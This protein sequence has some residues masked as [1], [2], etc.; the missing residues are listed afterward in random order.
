MLWGQ[1]NRSYVIWWAY[2][3]ATCTLYGQGNTEVML[4]DEHTCTLCRQGNTEVMLYNEHT[5]ML[6]G[7]GN[8]EVILFDEYTCILCRQRNTEII[9]WAYLLDM[10]A[11]K[12]KLCDMMSIPAGYEGKETQKLC[13]T[14]SNA[15]TMRARKH[16]SYY[17]MLCYTC[18]VDERSR[19][20]L[21]LYLHTMW[22]WKHRH[23][24]IRWANLHAMKAQKH[25][26]YMMSMPAHYEGKETQKLSI[27]WAN[28]HPMRAR[29][30]RSYL[31]NEHTCWIWGQG[32]TEVIYTMSKPAPYEARKH[33]SYL[34]Q[35]ANLHAMWA[36]P[37]I[38]MHFHTEVIQWAYCIKGTPGVLRRCLQG[39]RLSITCV[40]IFHGLPP[41]DKRNFWLTC[42]CLDQSCPVLS[43]QLTWL[44]GP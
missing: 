43:W 38:S 35:W 3:L 16:R 32:N 19:N 21:L 15:H 29:K 1:G 9:R 18:E 42:T 4:Y 6:W 11:S 5:C 28:L 27:Q 13:Y 14:M 36:F 30:H 2:L 20:P 7:Q 31:Y 41:V 40:I 8:T 23:Y 39:T 37:C 33:T 22:T 25:R 17:M 34:I 24:A 26:S 12:Q 10:K 44:K